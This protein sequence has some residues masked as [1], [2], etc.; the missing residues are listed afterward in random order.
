MRLLV[1]PMTATAPYLVRVNF[2]VC[3]HV[4]KVLPSNTLESFRK[5]AN[6]GFIHNDADNEH[7]I[8]FAIH[9]FGDGFIYIDQFSHSSM[10]PGSGTARLSVK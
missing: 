4:P 10:M 6:S 5:R 7:P 3:G 1:F 8:R 9:A 2:K